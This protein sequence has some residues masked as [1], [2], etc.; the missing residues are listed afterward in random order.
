VN[1]YKVIFDNNKPVLTN[2]VDLSYWNNT[3]LLKED[4]SINWLPVLAL[5]EQDSIEIAAKII[6]YA[7]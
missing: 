1:L 2:Q 6:A 5:N 4:G 7:L 3:D